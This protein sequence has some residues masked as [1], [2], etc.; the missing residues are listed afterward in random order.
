MCLCGLGAGHI[1]RQGVEKCGY[2]ISAANIAGSYFIR[3]VYSVDSQKMVL[4]SVYRY[5]WHG[6]TAAFR[7]CDVLQGR[8]SLECAVRWRIESGDLPNVPIHDDVRTLNPPVINIL[9][10]VSLARISVLGA[11]KGFEW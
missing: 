6:Q 2:F 7:A 11:E 5:W 1:S 3:R 4:G 10:G 8:V 9:I